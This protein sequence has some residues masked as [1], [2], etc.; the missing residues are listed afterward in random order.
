MCAA[1]VPVAARPTGW[2]QA[3]GRKPKGLATRGRLKRNGAFATCAEVN[4]TSRCEW[5]GPF[6]PQARALPDGEH[7]P[8][9]AGSLAT[10][11]QFLGTL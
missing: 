9:Y 2:P 3:W 7:R 10:K 5:A 4:P 8:D 6:Q 1:S 11:T